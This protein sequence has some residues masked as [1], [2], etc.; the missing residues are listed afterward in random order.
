MSTD[1]AA[2]VDLSAFAR[3]LGLPDDADEGAVV[4]AINAQGIDLIA[5]ALGL[6]AGAGIA[7]IL[8]EVAALRTDRASYIAHLRAEV[9]GKQEALRALQVQEIMRVALREARD[10]LDP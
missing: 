6:G 9:A 8:A 10:A 3:Q 1:E 4:A 7:G 5:A 2:K